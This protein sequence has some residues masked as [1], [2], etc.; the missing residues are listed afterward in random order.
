MSNEHT[1][2]FW[3]YLLANKTIVYNK[4]QLVMP[5]KTYVCWQAY[6]NYHEPV[7]MPQFQ[8]VALAQNIA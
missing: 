6:L 1:Q 2:T 3:M 4:P 8:Y 7:V 5:P